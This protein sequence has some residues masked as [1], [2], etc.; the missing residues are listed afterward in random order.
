MSVLDQAKEAENAYFLICNPSSNDELF[1]AIHHFIVH[2][3][4]II[5]ILQPLINGKDQFKE[6]KDDR[7][8]SILRKYS[9]LPI[10]PIS[11]IDIRNDL[12]HFDERIDFWVRES[13][14][15]IFMD[16]S[17]GADC[18]NKYVS[19]IDMMDWFRHFDFNNK[20]LYFCGKKYDIA[21][22]YN[23]AQKVRS[24]LTS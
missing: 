18:P 7:S 17:V 1:S 11:D 16:K 15:K 23:Y 8:K 21:A 4:N 22:L 5:K 14:N 20:V 9:N 12:E 2:V 19:G 13:K 24:V 6:F 10:I 3:S